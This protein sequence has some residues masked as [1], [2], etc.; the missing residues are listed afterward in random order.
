MV[1]K[2]SLRKAKWDSCTQTRS[3]PVT[4]I[5]FLC[6]SAFPQGKP[7]SQSTCGML[8]EGEFCTHTPQLGED[9]RHMLDKT[10]TMVVPLQRWAKLTGNAVLLT[11]DEPHTCFGHLE[12]RRGVGAS[13]HIL[14]LILSFQGMRNKGCLWTTKEAPTP[15]A[16][17]AA[18]SPPVHWLT[19]TQPQPQGRVGIASFGAKSMFWALCCLSQKWQI[20]FRAPGVT[21]PKPGLASLA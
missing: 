1:R 21:E 12:K 15:A 13:S 18:L 20:P 17:A 4:K 8:G 2:L 11:W 9:T 3:R 19:E 7:S 10:A 6:Q 5:G 16:G 14:F